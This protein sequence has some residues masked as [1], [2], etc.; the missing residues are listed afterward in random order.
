M[1]YG[2]EIWNSKGEKALEHS[3][4][5]ARLVHSEVI[6]PH[7]TTNSSGT[8]S[9]PAIAGYKTVEISLSVHSFVDDSSIKLSR[10]GTDIDWEIAEDGTYTDS[11]V[12]VFMYT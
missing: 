6:V 8:I 3:D 7:P 1:A 11:I 5:L 4:K 9:I 10:N 2:V 12:L